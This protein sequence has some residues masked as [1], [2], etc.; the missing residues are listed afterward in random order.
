[1]VYS[2][3][4]ESLAKKLTKTKLAIFVLQTKLNTTRSTS[5]LFQYRDPR[6]T[7]QFINVLDGL[8][9]IQVI[10]VLTGRSFPSISLLCLLNCIFDKN[11]SEI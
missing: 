10:Y 7:I 6:A 1:M 11:A 5:G 2:G 9:C 3:A 8:N 4:P